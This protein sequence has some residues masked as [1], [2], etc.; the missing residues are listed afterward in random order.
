MGRLLF[1]ETTVHLKELSDGGAEPSHTVS[2]VVDHGYYVCE[3]QTLHHH[4]HKLI[5]ATSTRHKLFQ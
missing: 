4:F 5:V 2:A 1:I 3:V